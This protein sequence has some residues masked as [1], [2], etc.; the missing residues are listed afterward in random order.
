MLFTACEETL[1]ERSSISESPA[2]A[3]DDTPVEEKEE[4]EEEEAAL[5]KVHFSPISQRR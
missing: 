1:R 2:A 3:S 4:K 5:F